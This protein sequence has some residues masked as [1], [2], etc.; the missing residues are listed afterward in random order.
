MANENTPA[1]TKVLGELGDSSAPMVDMPLPNVEMP[2]PDTKLHLLDHER[3]DFDVKVSQGG[4]GAPRI[5]VPFPFSL[6]FG[7]GYLLVSV[8]KPI[9]G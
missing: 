4:H 6:V 2:L 8:E 1:A 3:R 5:T 7:E 9:P